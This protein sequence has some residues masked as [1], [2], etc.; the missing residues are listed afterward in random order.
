MSN[1]QLTDA[2]FL[3][4]ASHNGE[5]FTNSKQND[6]LFYCDPHQKFLLGPKSADDNTHAP[7]ALA[8]HKVYVNVPCHIA[9]LH[10]TQAH[11]SNIHTPVFTTDSF[12][13]EDSHGRHLHISND[14]HV[15]AHAVLTNVNANTLTASNIEIRDTMNVDGANARVDFSNVSVSNIETRDIFSTR[16]AFSQCTV[17]D[18]QCTHT[19]SSD[20]IRTPQLQVDDRCDVSSFIGFSRK[21]G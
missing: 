17:D 7:L 18:L 14:L 8:S 9:E 1:S 21:K 2:A 5:I 11:F 4:V 12:A 20:G 19:L 15:D 10:G 6:I 16:A 13:F 3:Q